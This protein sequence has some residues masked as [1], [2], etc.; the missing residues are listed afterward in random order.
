MDVNAPRQVNVGDEFTVEGGGYPQ[1]SDAA[2]TEW[3]RLRDA[4]IEANQ[5]TPPPPRQFVYL[6]ISY[7][8]R[9]ELYKSAVS[10]QADQGKPGRFSYT[11]R[12]EEAGAARI[13]VWDQQQRNAL[14]EMEV[15]VVG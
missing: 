6:A 4:A 1:P 15:N 12:A 13:V 3:E 9:G 11:V 5:P 8:H 7:E 10:T 14:A 2:W